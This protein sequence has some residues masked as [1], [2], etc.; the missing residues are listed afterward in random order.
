M[1]TNTDT[2]ACRNCGT[3][4]TWRTSAKT[5]KRYLAQIKR[6]SGDYTL[7]EMSFYPAHKCT[8]DLAY[9]QERKANEQRAAANHQCRLDEGSIIK[10]QHVTV[11][12][13]K[14]VP[15]GTAGT[16]TWIAKEIAYDTIRIGITDDAGTI[17]YTSITNVEATTQ[18]T[19]ICRTCLGVL[20]Y[21]HNKCCNNTGIAQEVQS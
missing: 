3:E 2:F 18:K 7:N 1:S 12:R 14:K 19:S 10:G 20:A 5:G 9:M 16:I 21:T 8:P 15:K 4:V 13:G 17:H 11:V 6:W